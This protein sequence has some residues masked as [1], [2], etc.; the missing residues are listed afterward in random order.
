MP[1][2]NATRPGAIP[3]QHQLPGHLAVDHLNA[4][5]APGNPAHI[6]VP[7]PAHMPCERA[8]PH[9]AAAAAL[10]GAGLF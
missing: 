9:D 10:P 6:K 8:R 4:V 1:R 2:V 5:P 7:R 3:Y